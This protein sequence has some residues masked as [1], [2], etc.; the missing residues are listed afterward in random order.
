MT[1]RH[2]GATQVERYNLPEF[3]A[4]SRWENEGGA[5]HGDDPRLLDERR[6]GPLTNHAS[7]R[8]NPLAMREV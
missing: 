6:R 8:S 7:T 3:R 2:D 1:W 4:L 5:I